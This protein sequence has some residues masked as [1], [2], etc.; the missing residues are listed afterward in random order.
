MSTLPPLC[1]VSKTVRQNKCTD[2]SGL[3]SAARLTDVSSNVEQ[4]WVSNILFLTVKNTV[5]VSCSY[6]GLGL[7][8]RFWIRYIRIPDCV[9]NVLWLL[10]QDWNSR[11]PVCANSGITESGIRLIYCIRLCSNRFY[12]QVLPIDRLCMRRARRRCGHVRDL[13]TV[14]IR[15]YTREWLDDTNNIP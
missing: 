11:S 10:L 6:T 3:D 12:L 2:S 1:T 4:P 7:G 15:K 9:Q 14:F 13:K 5:T 8:L